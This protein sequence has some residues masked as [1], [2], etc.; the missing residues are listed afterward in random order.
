MDHISEDI[1]QLISAYTTGEINKGQFSDLKQWLEEA[2]EHKKIFLK[3]LHVHKTSQRIGFIDSLDEDQAWSKIEKQLESFNL[4][5]QKPNKIKRLKI[6]PRLLKYAA[7]AVV[8]ISVGYWYVS[9]R[10]NINIPDENITLQL[11]DGSIEIIK[12]NNTSNIVDIKGNVI[13]VQNGNQL[14]YSDATESETLKYNTLTV[15][16]GKRFEVM[17]SDGTKVN[18]NAGT[19]LKYPVKFIKGKD[20]QVFLDGEAYFTVAK[21]KAHPFIV[22][23]NNVNVRVLGTQFNMSSYPED[24]A[25][26]TVLVEGSVSVYDKAQDYNP[27]TATLLEPGYKA[28]WHKT[29]HNITIEKADV[30]VHTAWVKG[31]I[32]LKHIPFDNIVKKLERH[33]NVVINNQNTSLGKD[34]ITATFDIETI[35][36]VFKYINELHPI[37]YTI[38]NN[39]ITI[40]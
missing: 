23:A 9:N 4:E 16:Y 5:A 2:P 35:D 33:Y 32:I 20:R 26:S 10:S 13:G 12:L 30:E 37:E 34:F 18:L 6:I 21:D 24:N 29:E 31:K 36:Q 19:S 7:V 28:D 3:Y 22:N 25:I 38:Q 27:N 15:P 1:L 39:L 17:L 40:K 11:E 8:L 14:A